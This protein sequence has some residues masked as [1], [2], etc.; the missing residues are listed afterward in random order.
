MQKILQLKEK[1]ETSGLRIHQEITTDTKII[2]LLIEQF[3]KEGKD[4]AE[5][6]RQTVNLF[7]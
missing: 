1:Y 6:F 4:V 3:I 5:A 2:P 7:A